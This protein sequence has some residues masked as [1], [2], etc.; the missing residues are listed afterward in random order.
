MNTAGIIDLLLKKGNWEGGEP[1]DIQSLKSFLLTLLADRFN[2]IYD[3]FPD[4][5]PSDY[6][7]YKGVAK[8][9]RLD[10]PDDYMEFLLRS[11]REIVQLGGAYGMTIYGWSLMLTS[12]IDLMHGSS[13]EEDNPRYWVNVAERGD[14]GYIFLCCDTQ[15]PLYGKVAEFYDNTP[16][17]CNGELWHDDL[18]GTFEEYMLM[19]IADFGSKSS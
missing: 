4:L 12:T 15:S 13:D 5:R 14:K 11:D 3:Q 19:T 10:L 2:H 9:G 7:V 1:W 18:Y 17:D 16:W 6:A 8:G